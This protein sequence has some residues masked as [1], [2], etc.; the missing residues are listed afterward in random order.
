MPPRWGQ[1]R[2]F[3]QWQGY[4]ETRTDHY[5]YVKV[6]SDRSTLGTMVSMGSDGDEV[7]SRMW[8]VVWRHQLRLAAEEEFWKGL[9]GDEVHDVTSTIPPTV[10]PMPPYLVRF[11]K[12]VLHRTDPEIAGLTRDEAQSLWDE[13]H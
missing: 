10:E 13:F 6:L 2:E 11:L 7:P 12:S 9:Q 1:V 5:R 8:T 3:C 4:R